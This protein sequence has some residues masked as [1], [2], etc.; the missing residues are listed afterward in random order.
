M[1]LDPVEKNCI[2]FPSRLSSVGVWGDY[3]V[4]ASSADGTNTHQTGIAEYDFCVKERFNP[5]IS[6]LVPEFFL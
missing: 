6:I 2:G 4:F 1:A 5:Q 3:P